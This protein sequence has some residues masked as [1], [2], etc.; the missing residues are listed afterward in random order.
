MKE[1]GLEA[2][3]FFYLYLICIPQIYSRRSSSAIKNHNFFIFVMFVFF[4]KICFSNGKGKG[5]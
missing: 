3:E 2:I 1:I 4:L 5:G